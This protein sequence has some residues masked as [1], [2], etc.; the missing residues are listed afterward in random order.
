MTIVPTHGSYTTKTVVDN[1]TQNTPVKKEREVEQVKLNDPLQ[2]NSIWDVLFNGAGLK[3]KYGEDTFK[4]RI[5]AV[6]D[7]I[8]KQYWNPMLKGD[9]K[10]VGV[11]TLV[12]LGETL[13]VGNVIKALLP[14]ID[15][16]AG[17]DYDEALQAVSAIQD[18][19]AFENV[20]FQGNKYY[21]AQVNGMSKRFDEKEYDTYCNIVN[22][23]RTVDITKLTTGERVAASLGFGEYG[24]INYN[25]DTGNLLGDIILE[26]VLD[27]TTWLS[28]GASAGVK[29]AAKEV[30]GEVAETVGEKAAK[31]VAANAMQIWRSGKVVIEN[32][33]PLNTILK[34]VLGDAVKQN[35]IYNTY[36]LKNI[37]EAVAIA[38]KRSSGLTDDI[39]DA[40]FRDMLTQ[41]ANAYVNR[42][43]YTA[44][45]V[46][47]TANTVNDRVQSALLKLTLS[48]TG[49]YPLIYIAKHSPA[50]AV[51]AKNL[52]TTA[53]KPYVN[54]FGN[55]P[56]LSFIDSAI[57]D[58]RANRAVVVS[59]PDELR[60][61][62]VQPNRIAQHE[63]Q[64]INDTAWLGSWWSRVTEDN[65]DE[66][67]TELREYI[68]KAQS[69]KG[70]TITLEDLAERLNKF[71]VDS[72]IDSK[73]IRK[74]ADDINEVL[75]FVQKVE[76]RASDNASWGALQ[77]IYDAVEVT[78]LIPTTTL[79][80]RRLDAGVGSGTITDQ[81]IRN[82]PDLAAYTP[83]VDGLPVVTLEQLRVNL[84]IA[85]SDYVN[86]V[87]QLMDDIVGVLPASKDYNDSVMLR[88]Q[89][90]LER[91]T[92]DIC[93][94]YKY[95]AEDDDLFAHSVMEL[96][97]DQAQVE[98]LKKI[99][100]VYNEWFENV[101]LF[102]FGEPLS[103]NN[104]KY[105]SGFPNSVD[106]E[107]PDFLTKPVTVPE[108]ILA[109]QK[110]ANKMFKDSEDTMMGIASKS[111]YRSASQGLTFIDE[112]DA[113][114][115]DL[116]SILDE[117][118]EVADIYT[119]SSI[120]KFGKAY[121]TH[122]KVTGYN[123]ER[124]RDDITDLFT[125]PRESE[126]YAQ[127]YNRTTGALENAITILRQKGAKAGDD[128]TYT[129][130]DSFIES[131][132]SKR[133]DIQD[134][135]NPEDVVAMEAKQDAMRAELQKQY[136]KEIAAAQKHATY[137]TPYNTLAQRA[138]DTLDKFQEAYAPHK[139]EE[140]I[141]SATG[142]ED[143]VYFKMENTTVLQ[144]LLSNP[145]VST[146]VQTLNDADM[147]VFLNNLLDASS[148]LTDEGRRTVKYL[149][150]VCTS[151]A[152]TNKFMYR[153]NS[154]DLDS[155]TIAGIL[156]S[157]NK[158]YHTTAGTARE[159]SG[160]FIQNVIEQAENYI[161][162]TFK[163]N[164]KRS[165]DIL[166]DDAEFRPFIDQ[167]FKNVGEV[168]PEKE[169]HT[170]LSD[171]QIN[172]GVALGLAEKDP[173]LA[174]KI[175][176][177]LAIVYD[178]EALNLNTS[179]LGNEIHQ[180][181]FV[182]YYKGKE[183]YRYATSIDP[184]SVTYKNTPDAEYLENILGA[185]FV[186][187]HSRSECAAEYANHLLQGNT[188]NCVTSSDE[189]LLSG[190][191]EINK[192]AKQYGEY[193]EL[194]K[195]YMG[196]TMLG[197]NISK[198][199]DPL[200]N[201]TLSQK[202]LY[203][204]AIEN[205]AY[206]F[207]PS[208]F[209]K[210]GNHVDTF[211]MI[212]KADELFEIP[213][214][215]RTQVIHVLTQYLEDME[216]ATDM[217]VFTVLN[218]QETDTIKAFAKEL[219]NVDDPDYFTLGTRLAGDIDNA[220]D[221]I[222]G[223]KNKN[224][225]LS[226][227]ILPKALIEN[228]DYS[229]VW[230]T[231]F[232][233]MGLTDE[234]I[235]RRFGKDAS[236]VTMSA[237]MGL[238]GDI[239]NI[240]Y[241]Y[242]IKKAAVNRWFSG[243][244]AAI[245]SNKIKDTEL[246]RLND[247]A[248]LLNNNA[249]KVYNIDLM[250]APELAAAYQ[251]LID[252]CMALDD[253][254]F[255]ATYL[256]VQELNSTDQYALAKYCFKQLKNPERV[257]AMLEDVPKDVR[258]R[259]T[260]MLSNAP[261][262]SDCSIDPIAIM[263][264]DSKYED[265]YMYQAVVDNALE[266]QTSLNSISEYADNK[267]ISNSTSIRARAMDPIL[268]ATR[269]FNVSSSGDRA[270]YM[271]EKEAFDKM[272]QTQTR[273]I[274]NMQA[275]DMVNWI[276]GNYGR[277]IVIDRNNI[278]K[279]LPDKPETAYLNLIDKL[280]TEEFVNAKIRFAEYD[281]N[282]IVYLDRSA[283]LQV[284]LKDGK[285]EFHVCNTLIEPDYPSFSW[286]AVQDV[287][288]NRCELS[289]IEQALNVLDRISQTNVRGSCW[290]TM[291]K[292]AFE[293]FWKALPQ[294]IQTVATPFEIMNSPMAWNGATYNRTFLGSGAMRKR[295]GVISTER[296]LSMLANATNYA[297][298]YGASKDVYV[299]A[300]LSD[301]TSVHRTALGV[302]MRDEPK[303]VV[304]WIR[305]N[306]DYTFGALVQ[307]TKHSQGYRFEIIDGSTEA[308]VRRAYELNAHVMSCSEANKFYEVINEGLFS[309]TKMRAWQ[310]LV[311]FYKI[312]YLV[313]PGTWLRNSL[314]AFIKNTGETGNNGLAM[315]KRTAIAMHDISEYDSICRE[316]N[317]MGHGHRPGI[318]EIQRWFN[319]MH[320]TGM[321]YERFRMI[322]A[323][324]SSAEA[325][326]EASIFTK[327][328][329][330]ARKRYNEQLAAVGAITTD[331]F[332][333]KQFRLD[334]NQATNALLNPMNYVERI[335]RFALFDELTTQGYN[336]TSAL[337]SV[338]RT[339]FSYSVKSNLEQT[340]EL[341]VPFYTFA[342]RN[343]NYWLDTIDNNPAYFSILRDV[344]APA[345]DLDDYSDNERAD[346][347]AVGRLISS[348]NWNFSGDYYFNLNLST[349]DALKWLTNPLD[350]GLNSVFSPVQGVI[351]AF[352]QETADVAY[353]NGSDVLSQF[354][355]ESFNLKMTEK[356]VEDKYGEWAT[357]YKELYDF[358]ISKR[359]IADDLLTTKVLWQ[360][361][362]LIGSQI[363]KMQNTGVYIDD[364]D[365]LGGLL[366]FAGLGGKT[367]RWES[368]G[369][370]KPYNQAIFEIINNSPEA[371]EA[372]SNI[373]K[374]LGLTGVTLKDIPLDAKRRILEI[375]QSGDMTNIYRSELYQ[376]SGTN[377]YNLLQAD[378]KNVTLYNQLKA[379][380]GYG[381]AQ[382]S[383]LPDD[384]KQA[385]YA[386]MKQETPVQN[387]VPVL[388]NAQAMQYI[389]TSV[390]RRHD[391]V[392]VPVEEIPQETLNEMYATI[393]ED[394]IVLA[395][396][397]QML[398]NDEDTRYTYAVAK[399]KLGFKNLKLYQIPVEALQVIQTAMQNKY[400]GTE[401][402]SS[403]SSAGQRKTY[404]SYNKSRYVKDFT[405]LYYNSDKAKWASYSH[406]SVAKI[407]QY[408]YQNFY[409]NNYSSNGS[410]RVALQML[411]NGHRQID[412]T[413]LKFMR[414]NMKYSFK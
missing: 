93:R 327:L 33:D 25:A 71:V 271:A 381:D 53:A 260:T 318:G 223:I 282:I 410:S 289:D 287:Y 262:R 350:Q 180:F 128:V 312:G 239:P 334:Y 221:A 8:S 18:G 188:V 336:S 311:R 103:K 6:G 59:L 35:K 208:V 341:V 222:V 393:A 159:H 20:D 137:N 192:L 226:Q 273:H 284:Y 16:T 412:P 90:I 384:V 272:T 65:A 9:F 196:V 89:D 291:G 307:D 123:I 127:I 233:K 63:T 269:D 57:N 345:M 47:D 293:R 283:N 308:G 325:G 184:A 386:I 320:K 316:L 7:I 207:D 235:T 241:S 17:I 191:R 224:K 150:N 86:D 254:S 81:F 214:A 297:T 363:Q 179:G 309:E 28:L 194:S 369:I 397:Y 237:L 173:D 155:Q 295:F 135:V 92:E 411:N 168:V 172:F 231:R 409:K 79:A 119:D 140:S 148:E 170:V 408:E 120:E 211:D 356:E 209:R 197:H 162:Y 266:L 141:C 56:V 203:K 265:L 85:T 107:I 116:Y 41:G 143:M 206:G 54:E 288:R 99:R 161:N 46:L 267:L 232:H 125:T 246:Q 146:L 376:A 279:L 360:I 149:Q 365:Y 132:I 236:N 55:R 385:I 169:L 97:T 355:Q 199:D 286:E 230:L 78:D 261:K 383:D 370:S 121:G 202:H 340:L 359:G 95:A 298:E 357:T 50:A 387:I 212:K 152:A 67:V 52:L 248:R 280:S 270:V 22:S 330:K 185:D 113:T 189:V 302:G 249:D 319:E 354:L 14:G 145:Q 101:Y 147:Q 406:N 242:Q 258:K 142:L 268:R 263:A 278:H 96:F 326:S 324:Q 374:A 343:L 304:S 215:D 322:D 348:G 395:D 104:I 164:R 245:R 45:R 379:V 111:G 80:R 106:Y 328:N 349:F 315:M 405:N 102:A 353:E 58:Q 403:G 124:L 402:K 396:I 139:L 39:T 42:A 94:A 51:W 115:S 331:E 84:S 83:G 69:P 70:A 43:A 220:V 285:S 399:N 200:I 27:P 11:N 3:D 250:C 195:T 413:S 313:N 394:A 23:G 276:A 332:R 105:I 256:R 290:D 219:Q 44:L 12:T 217:R 367:T 48:P 225:E 5:K 167:V 296:P 108:Q 36:T 372:Y 337:R 178:T 213:E 389:W 117:L 333:K 109:S 64:C 76:K 130:I 26:L 154:S 157:V 177:G 77:K 244:D 378:Y 183:V 72:N 13:D 82:L 10:T 204:E 310:T 34:D 299:Q 301:F 131:E 210:V 136:A 118:D 171:A 201:S 4:S 247:A 227:T 144:S 251:E 133:Y 40:A 275:P 98:L 243:V 87:W 49:F 122:G 60:A 19:Q 218:P 229:E 306:P 259:V 151:Y 163:G 1:N 305:K 198:F 303:S 329:T 321:D 335:N 377:I 91:N 176:D 281:N 114:L 38:M 317:K 228:K 407:K 134:L 73:V 252:K 29:N 186:A 380:M 187:S 392:D 100:S 294:D 238:Q 31:N 216:D 388:G 30:A 366:A 181:G 375:L 257:E 68:S 129:N 314:D 175:N 112:N 61:S 156:S 21:V 15:R 414:Q 126:E 193:D 398:S 292:D 32:N 165:L 391:M 361:V 351:E 371:M 338:D 190:M 234:E 400:Y 364:Q 174:A 88:I 346:N 138:Q 382:L 401:P 255:L 390:A 62:Y 323:F 339:H 37:K 182:A 24:R 110:S 277:P 300:M 75:A 66:M 264:E 347:N 358:R 342:S 368:S 166:K 153:L 352:L 205:P 373:K 160:A 344:L 274:Y 158:M 253:F 74:Y 404:K 240:A 2:L 362:P